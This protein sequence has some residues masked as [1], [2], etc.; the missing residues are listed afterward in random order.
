MSVGAWRGRCGSGFFGPA[1]DGDD[2]Q[3]AGCTA[4]GGVSSVPLAFA[5]GARP[6][7]ITARDGRDRYNV[8]RTGPIPAERG[9]DR[10]H[11]N[12][13]LPEE[14]RCRK[15]L[16]TSARP[17]SQ[18]FRSLSCYFNE[19]LSLNYALGDFPSPV[20]FKQKKAGRGRANKLKVQGF[21]FV[22]T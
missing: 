21:S 16:L 17:R 18:D 1:V 14:R 4:G 15:E 12:S 7:A 8:T 5:S 19:P 2:D 22:E 20:V 9:V 11:N 6:A 10:E 13:L 3:A